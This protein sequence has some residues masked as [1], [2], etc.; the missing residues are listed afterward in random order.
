MKRIANGVS[1]MG[2]KAERPRNKRIKLVGGGTRMGRQ[3]SGPSSGGLKALRR[4]LRHELKSKKLSIEAR[5]ALKARLAV[6]LA[7][8]DG[9]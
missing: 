9:R 6:L 3:S 4:S 2:A 8:K 5:R 1:V 7:Q